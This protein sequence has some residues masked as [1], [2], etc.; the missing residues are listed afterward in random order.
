MLIKYL[1]IHFTDKE[2][3]HNQSYCAKYI[4]SGNLYHEIG[5][6]RYTGDVYIL[7]RKF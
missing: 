2:I 7:I 1:A 5:L 3:M 6:I 4:L